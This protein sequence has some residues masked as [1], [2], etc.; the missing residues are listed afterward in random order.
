[1]ELWKEPV[2]LPD[3]QFLKQNRGSGCFQVSQ[4]LHLFENCYKLLELI[5]FITNHHA[6]YWKDIKNICF[7]GKTW[8]VRLKTWTLVGGVFFL[9][10]AKLWPSL[11]PLCPDFIN[12]EIGLVFKLTIPWPDRYSMSI[13]LSPSN[14]LTEICSHPRPPPIIRWEQC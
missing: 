11:S 5:I 7:V 4:K 14:P 6:A 8:L 3:P 2:N 1:M 13:V 9:G 10:A 12:V